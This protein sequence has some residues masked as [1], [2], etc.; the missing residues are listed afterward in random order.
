MK[1][2][3]L[4]RVPLVAFFGIAIFFISCSKNSVQ[5][6]GSEQAHLNEYEN[7]LNKVFKKSTNLIKTNQPQTKEQFK[8]ILADSYVAVLGENA[9]L[10]VFNESFSKIG[11]SRMERRSDFAKNK[12][13]EIM[14]SSIDENKAIES[15][16]ILIN[17]ENVSV[18]DKLDFINMKESLVFVAENHKFI[19]DNLLQ[20]IDNKSFKPKPKP[21]PVKSWW[22][23]WGKCVSGTLGGAITTGGGGLLAGASAGTI[24][25]PLVGT[26]FGAAVGG[27]LGL[28]GG[29]L[30]GAAASC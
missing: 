28:V 7:E 17:D 22:D 4:K 12:I 3:I 8:A 26:V 27:V 30:V 23:S 2:I 16:E 29:A 21:A 15:L 18:E 11:S 14:F 9:R 24:V 5:S 1:K 25:L 13:S 20:K 10:N 19:E 6:L